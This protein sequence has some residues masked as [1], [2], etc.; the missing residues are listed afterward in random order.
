MSDIDDAVADFEDGLNCC[1]TILKT[2]GGLLGI[3]RE[4]ALRLGTGFGGGIARHGAVCGAVSGAVMVIGIKYGMTHKNDT[5]AK[6]KTY[7]LVSEFI[8]KFKT[9]HNSIICKDLLGCDLSTPEGKEQA[10]NED[11]FKKECPEFV[12]TAAEILEKVL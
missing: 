10:K 11:K 4:S 12:R 5:E 9:K 8:D 2:Y 7:E 1:Q 3:A 6:D